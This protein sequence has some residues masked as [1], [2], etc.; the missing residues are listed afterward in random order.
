MLLNG[1]HWIPSI[2]VSHFGFSNRWRLGNSWKCT[3]V[4]VDNVEKRFFSQN[5]I[6]YCDRRSDISRQDI[7]VITTA[8]LHS[9]KPEL[10]FRFKFAMVR[11]SVNDD[12]SVMSSWCCKCSF[13][14][15]A[16]HKRVPVSLTSFYFCKGNW[17]EFWK[18]LV[19]CCCCYSAKIGL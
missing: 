2:V 4:K 10:K 13:G 18:T 1:M 8:Q 12:I 19:C 15:H 14:T 17:P 3:A 11:I 7:V 16:M 5:E 9:T 6:N